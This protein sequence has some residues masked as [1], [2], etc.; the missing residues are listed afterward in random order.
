[1][2]QYLLE[3]FSVL[4]SIRFFA[5]LF[6]V[7]LIQNTDRACGENFIQMPFNISAELF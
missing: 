2:P 3:S 5:L 7:V 1:M 6:I 4:L